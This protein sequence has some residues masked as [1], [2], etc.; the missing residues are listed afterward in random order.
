MNPSFHTKAAGLFLLGILAL[1]GC[2]AE[3]VPSP[4]DAGSKVPADSG[5]NLGCEPPQRECFERC[6]DP[7]TDPESCGSCGNRCPQGTVCQAGQCMGSCG[8]GLADCAGACVDLSLDREHCSACG[9]ACQAGFTCDAARCTC[10]EGTELCGDT[11]VDTVS[12]DEHCGAC[13][14]ACGPKESC[15]KGQCLCATGS[16]EMECNDQQDNDCDGKID[17]ADEDC[18]GLTR[19]CSGAC[20]PGIEICQ[21]DGSWGTCEGGDGSTEICGDGIDQDCDG[22]DLRMPDSYE[23]NNYCTNCRLLTPEENP[24]IELN[25]PTFDALGDRVDCFRVRLNDTVIYRERLKIYLTNIPAGHDYDIY[26]YQ[27]LDACEMDHALA[28]SQEAGNNNEHI[29]WP[30]RF[31]SSDSGT[32]FIKVRRFLGYSCSESYRIR[33]EGFQ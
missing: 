4:S 24:I 5:V 26:L 29:D 7:Q 25:D 10:P 14:Q 6:I 32:Y 17:C 33:I 23:P 20:G 15:Q 13:N 1:S 27:D 2:G 12:N 8:G 28:S 22:E 9:Q 21:Q 31:G 16:K 30:E 3:I 19:S 11:C 18:H